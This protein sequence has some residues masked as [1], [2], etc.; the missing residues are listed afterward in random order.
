MIVRGQESLRI[1]CSRPLGFTCGGNVRM[2]HS[3][4]VQGDDQA[5]GQREVVAGKYTSRLPTLLSVNDVVGRD[6]S[7]SVARVPDHDDIPHGQRSAGILVHHSTPAPQRFRGPTDDVVTVVRGEQSCLWC[8]YG[9]RNVERVVLLLLTGLLPQQQPSRRAAACREHRAAGCEA[10]EQTPPRHCRHSARRRRRGE[11]SYLTFSFLDVVRHRA[12]SPHPVGLLRRGERRGDLSGGRPRHSVLGQAGG[13]ERVQL[14]GHA[15][16]ARLAMDDFV[17]HG[18]DVRALERAPA[19]GRVH[20]DG[21]Q[22]EHVGCGRDPPS[23]HLLRGAVPGCDR[24]LSGRGEGQAV[25]GACD[26]EVDHSRTGRR[27]H[28]V[29]GL[30]V[31]VDEPRRVNVRQSARN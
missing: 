4:G 15:F 9:R 6:P 14:R 10:G 19:G 13:H 21:T 1:G 25:L 23:Q 29:L 30:E 5:V 22:G 17:L 8:R 27:Q 11:L 28:D 12:S 3:V 31:T 2:Q 7:I 20:E 24:D 26:A 16:P 18:G